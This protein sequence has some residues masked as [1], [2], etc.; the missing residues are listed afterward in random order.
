MSLEVIEEVPAGKSAARALSPGQAIKIM[1]G[2]PVPAGADA[3]LMR[4]VAE[5]MPGGFVR[6]NAQ[7]KPGQNVARRASDTRAGAPVLTA[8]QRLGAGEIGILAAVGC[9]AVPVRP[10][11]DVAVL[12]TGDE[13]VEPGVTPG[14]SQIRNSNSA[15]LLAQ[16]A[17]QRLSARYLGIAP[18]DAVQTRALIA[19]GLRAGLFV[20]TGGVSVGD[21]DYVGASFKDLGVNVFFDKVQIKPGKPTTFG[22]FRDGE[23][24]TLVFGLPGNPVAAWVCFKLFV[25]TAVRVRCG[26]RNPLPEW[27]QLP[28]LEST[29]A[30]EASRLTFRPCRLVNHE[31]Q[32][33]VSPIEWHGSGHPDRTGGRNRTLRATRRHRFSRCHARDVLSIM[34]RAATA[35]EPANVARPT[36]ASSWRSR[37]LNSDR[38]RQLAHRFPQHRMHHLRRDLRQRFE[39]EQPLVQARVWHVQSGF[40]DH[41]IFVE[42]H[43]QID[44]ARLVACAAGAVPAEAL[45]NLQ[46]PREQG[47]RLKF[48][49]DFR[50]AV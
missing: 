13:L 29:P 18:D 27:L 26:A 37:S 11:P 9:V 47:V 7:V 48:C 6:V 42:Q 40:V 10:L 34:K 14:P 45:F 15:Q 22:L 25:L 4:E 19:D 1:T 43:V 17:E 46:K 23:R 49:F 3:V 8:G 32:T 28:L 33:K 41:A 20:S 16:C 44:R 36:W 31:G 35:K 38:L 21:H 2:A 24:E 39:H 12:G 5:A 30:A 50:H